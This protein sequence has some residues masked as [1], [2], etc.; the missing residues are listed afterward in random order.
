MGGVLYNQ[1][2]TVILIGLLLAL[3][4]AEA[5]CRRVGVQHR[6]SA[7]PDARSQVGALEGAVLGL[8]ALLLGFTF[9]MAGQRFDA[10]RELTQL[11]AN[12]IRTAILRTDLIAEPE[13]G[14]LKRMLT[15]YVDLRIEF[16]D[17]HFDAAKLA[18]VGAKIERAHKEIWQV[19]AV[20]ARRDPSETTSLLVSSVNEVIERHAAR[21]GALYNNVPEPVMWFL[22][23]VS[24]LAAGI[25][26]YASGVSDTRVWP[27]TIIVIFLVAS[28]VM[29]I[30]DLDRP[31]RGLI[32]AGQPAMLELQ[33]SLKSSAN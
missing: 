6:E 26:G 11:D 25:A 18:A 3:F 24:V 29:M 5:A 32:T 8:L 15:R 16:Y 22:L 21:I 13:S 4:G 31:R 23:A 10:R 9:S 14:A 12:A 19:T 20:A 33:Q 1:S 27:S 30:I 28:V 17:A 7:G 2:Q